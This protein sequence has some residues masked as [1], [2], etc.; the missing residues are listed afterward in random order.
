MFWK[1]TCLYEKLIRKKATFLTS[2]TKN[3]AT[4]QNLPLKKI[5]LINAANPKISTTIKIALSQSITLGSSNQPTH[6]NLQKE[7]NL[8]N[9]RKFQT[10]SSTPSCR[11]IKPSHCIIFYNKK[12]EI[13]IFSLEEIWVN[14]DRLFNPKNALNYKPHTRF[15]NLFDTSISS[16]STCST[17]K[18][19]ENLD[20]LNSDILQ[21]NN[22]IAVK[23]AF[24]S[25]IDRLCSCDMLK[26]KYQ[27]GN[28][29]IEVLASIKRT[30]IEHIKPIP[31]W[32]LLDTISGYQELATLEMNSNQ[33]KM[34]SEPRSR[35]PSSTSTLSKTN[36]HSDQP[37]VLGSEELS[38]DNKQS[39][40]LDLNNLEKLVK[41]SAILENDTI[42]RIGCYNFL[43]KIEDL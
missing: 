9:P 10:I 34:E 23:K 14:D 12:S 5:T 2:T 7:F 24:V 13:E 29:L 26:R 32:A 40:L 16:F 42:L 36:D 17:I 33:D 20:K 37:Q 25:P 43:V 1:K 18:S 21:Y 30:A 38:E 6:I 31:E 28:D 15:D 4:P 19:Q 39:K 11:Y 8:K 27:S 35:E 41:N 22:C 3:P